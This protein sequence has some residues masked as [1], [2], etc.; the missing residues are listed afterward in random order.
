M[1]SNSNA[2]IVNFGKT[3]TRSS[4][5][6]V[7][8]Q[9]SN[10]FLISNS[11]KGSDSLLDQDLNTSDDYESAIN[12]IIL[13]PSTSNLNLVTNKKREKR[14]HKQSTPRPSQASDAISDVPNSSSSAFGS[15]LHNNK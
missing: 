2:V 4:S 3:P 1:T 12:H 14:K 13:P 6:D 10:N 5:N 15:T 8:K 7:S 11:N 9:K